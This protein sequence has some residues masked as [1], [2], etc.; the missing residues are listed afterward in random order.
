MKYLFLIIY[1][2]PGVYNN[3]LEVQLE[4]ENLSIKPLNMS[5]RQNNSRVKKNGS[6]V[7]QKNL[8]GI[9]RFDRL[10]TVLCVICYQFSPQTF[11]N[12]GNVI[13]KNSAVILTVKCVNFVLSFCKKCYTS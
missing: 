5:I 2:Y 9:R 8:N 10:Q 1:C 12:L 13:A 4:Q 6:F 11:G 3:I 7:C